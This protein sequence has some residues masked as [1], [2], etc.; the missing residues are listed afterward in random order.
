MDT[1]RLMVLR[2]LLCFIFP[3]LLDGCNSKESAKTSRLQLENDSLRQKINDDQTTSS[4][5]KVEI[6]NTEVHPLAS[7][8][9]GHS[10]DIYVMF[11]K[12]YKTSKKNYPVLYVL[13]AE[14]N[15]GG[16]T[17]IVQRLIKDE[18]LPELF[19]VGIAYQG[20]YDEDA[21]YSI[22]GLDF[23]PTIDKEFSKTHKQ[24]KSGGAENF[25]QFLE[26]ELIPFISSGYP[27]KNESR[28]LYGHSFGGLFGFYSLLNHPNLFNNYLLLSPSLWWDRNSM[29]TNVKNFV[30]EGHTRLYVGT[31]SLE[32]SKHADTQHSMVDE[33]LMMVDQLVAKNTRNLEIKSEILEGETHRTIFG[34]GFTNGLRFIYLKPQK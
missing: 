10:Y 13:D 6:E 17:Y 16:V 23:T 33:H 19:V 3:M 2:I 1:P 32:N 12:D 29:S 7:K 5:Q 9:T 18:I 26:S 25:S 4:S 34:T 31:G 14:V 8:F 30:S 22:R 24:P 27:V 21:Y 11:P 20:E 28:S 15:F